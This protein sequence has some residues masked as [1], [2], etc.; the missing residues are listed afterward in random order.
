MYVDKKETHKF[1]QYEVSM[2]I[3][4]EWQIKEKYQNG[5]HLKTTSQ[6][7]LICI[8]TKYEVSL[9]KPVAGRGCAQ[10]PMLTPM[11]HDGQSVIV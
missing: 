10:S 6:N 2:S 9:F 5:C 8:C 7:H 11:T 3:W 1:I 4:A